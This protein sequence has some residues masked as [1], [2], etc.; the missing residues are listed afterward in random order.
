MPTIYE[1]KTGKA[2]P[3]QHMIDAKEAVANG[4]YTFAPPAPVE[5]KKIEPKQK[6]KPKPEIKTFPTKSKFTKEIKTLKKPIR[7]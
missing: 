6:A 5:K 7:K 3:V 1:V 2:I 4:S